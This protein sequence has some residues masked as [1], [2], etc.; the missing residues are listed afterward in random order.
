VEPRRRGQG[1]CAG[2]ERGAV[3]LWI[4]GLC[5]TVLFLGGLSLDLWRSFSTRRALA[6]AADAAAVAGA[7][8][9]DEGALRNGE[10]VLDPREAE[11]L[12]WESLA[13]QGLPDDVTG[14]DVL[15]EPD[16]V[17]VSLAGN[18]DLTL[19]KIFLGDRDLDVA[20]TARADPRRSP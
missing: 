7:N 4:L 6:E 12:A 11:Q 16:G 15:V 20:V 1:W 3:T 2:D 19:L 8:G 9:I 10:L 5:V 18:V 14:A 13:S 17:V